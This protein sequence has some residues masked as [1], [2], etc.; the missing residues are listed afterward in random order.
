AKLFYIQVIKQIAEKQGGLPLLF[1]AENF[2]LSSNILFLNF[3]VMLLIWT[4][5]L[6]IIGWSI[7]QGPWRLNEP[8]RK[9]FII[10][11][12]VLSVV[13]FFLSIAVARRAYDFWIVFGIL[14]IAAVFTGLWNSS[15]H[16]K[17]NSSYQ[18]AGGIL[19]T[20]LV[21]LVFYSGTKT[22][23]SLKSNSYPPDHVKAAGEWLNRNTQPGDLVYNL[24]WT[25]FSPLF[26][27]DRKNYYLNGLDPIFQ[28]D[29]NPAL[30]WK[31]NYLATGLTTNQTCGK[32]ECKQS[33]MEDTYKVLKN[34]FGAKY[35]L[36]G[37]SYNPKMEKF[38]A[39]SPNFEKVFEAVN[40]TIY[41]IK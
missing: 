18:W 32:T 38:L 27:W 21:F 7:W 29:Y 9:I 19:I 26:L 35:I 31:F 5:A 14:L 12:A 8:K 6:A 22:I 17:Q 40:E 34:D 10:S 24:H 37:K 20:A 33:D 1:G 11:S 23:N 41:R 25:H 4:V 28:Y 30:Y 39:G 36:V 2:P 16:R 15:I 13:F 3:G